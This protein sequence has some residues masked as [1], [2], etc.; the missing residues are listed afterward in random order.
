MTANGPSSVEGNPEAI[1]KILAT[2]LDNAIIYSKS[3]DSVEVRIVKTDG[4]CAID[5]VDEG[6]GIVEDAIPFIY[7]RFFRAAAP[8]IEGTGLGLVIAKS[9]AEREGITLSHRNRS[10]RSGLIAAVAFAR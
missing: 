5:A 2:L 6:P 7:D 10:D 1:R 9:T 8:G 3:D 4:D